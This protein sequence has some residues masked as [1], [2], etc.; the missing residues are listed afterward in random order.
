MIKS[1]LQAIPTCFICIF[2][3]PSSLG[4]EIGIKKNI[5]YSF[6]WGNEGGLNKEIKWLSW[7]KLDLKEK[8]DGMGFKISTCPT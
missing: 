7:S 1:V 6:W 2:L 4:D 3:V 8:D 5:N